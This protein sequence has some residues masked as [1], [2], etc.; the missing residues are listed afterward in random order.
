MLNKMKKWFKRLA[1]AS[2]FVAGLGIGGALASNAYIKYAA[3]ERIYAVDDAEMPRRHTA[4]VLGARVMPSGKPSTAL[5][6]RLHTALELYQAGKVERILVTGDN[7]QA[8]YNEV[9]AMFAWLNE[10][11]VPAAHI[12]TDHAGFRTLDSM[13]RARTVFGVESA[14]ICTQEFHLARSIFLARD[15]DIDAIGAIADRRTYA[16]RRADSRREF[17]A[18]TVAVADLYI[19]GRGPKHGGQKIPI[20]GDAS[21][22]WDEAI[23]A[24]ANQ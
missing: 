15:Q 22:S 3:S 11:G 4:I 21:K 13:Q 14:I 6:D 24:I 18:R 20:T 2:L 12:F 17:M 10:R 9:R 8:H 23:A 7:G 1:I 16:K 5:A 19:L